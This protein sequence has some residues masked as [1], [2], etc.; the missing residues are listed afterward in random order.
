MTTIILLSI[1][2]ITNIII[3]ILMYKEYQTRKMAE[4][5]LKRLNRLRNLK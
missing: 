4:Y 2:I 1:A 3:G 5:E